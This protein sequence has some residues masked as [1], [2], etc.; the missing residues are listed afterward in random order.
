[1]VMEKHRVKNVNFA[2]FMVDSAQANLMRLA[3]YLDP[4]TR[5]NL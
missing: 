3:R 5:A 2:R 1:M 4:V